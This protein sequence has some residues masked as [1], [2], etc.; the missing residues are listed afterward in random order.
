MASVSTSRCGQKELLEYEIDVERRSIESRGQEQEELREL[1][2]AR[3][4]EAELAKRLRRP[5]A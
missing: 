2:V 5:D 1:F 3:G 4:I